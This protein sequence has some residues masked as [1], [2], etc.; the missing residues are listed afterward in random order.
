MLKKYLGQYWIA[1]HS[2]R[3]AVREAYS[4]AFAKQH[5]FDENCH[6]DSHLFLHLNK[7]IVRDCIGEKMT[8]PFAYAVQ[9]EVFQASIV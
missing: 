9:I 7:P 6:R 3:G 4:G 8:E 2:Q 5:L 1:T